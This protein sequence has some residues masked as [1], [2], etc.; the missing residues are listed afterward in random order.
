LLPSLPSL[1]NKLCCFIFLLL[2]VVARAILF[3]YAGLIVLAKVYFS[4]KAKPPVEIATPSTRVA[5]ISSSRGNFPSPE[6]PGFEAYLDSKDFQ[7]Y[8]D[9]KEFEEYVESREFQELV[10]DEKAIETMFG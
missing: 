9:S 10:E 7:D 3:G 5:S 6:D 8:V 2:P 1:S 4:M